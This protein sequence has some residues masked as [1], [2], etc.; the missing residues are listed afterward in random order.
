MAIIS[1]LTR[2]HNEI[3][4]TKGLQSFYYFSKHGGGEVS[5]FPV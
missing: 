3:D 2:F 4:K 1:N 5:F